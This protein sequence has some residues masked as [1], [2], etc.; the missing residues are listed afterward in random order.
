MS[1][2]KANAVFEVMN[3]AGPGAA[4][5]GK[6]QFEDW[7]SAKAMTGSYVEGDYEV[8]VIG[9][10]RDVRIEV[11][12]KTAT[13]WSDAL[14]A[15]MQ[16]AVESYLL[17][18]CLRTGNA[19]EVDWSTANFV[20]ADGK[21]QVIGWSGFRVTK[22]RDPIQ[23]LAGYSAE[24][25]M[26]RAHPELRAALEQYAGSTL[27]AVEQPGASMALAYLAVEGLVTFVLG[28]TTGSLT[29]KNDWATTAPLLASHP[30]SLLRLLWSTQ[31]GRHVD[32]VRA[33]QELTNQGWTPLPAT[34]CCDLALDIVVAYASTL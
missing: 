6:A 19:L 30:D 13:D 21:R 28:S 9:K 18:F 27:L 8:T 3:F 24:A 34:D 2:D 4:L 23:A 26:I 33:R 12:S 32:P 17:G 29:S 22:V 20:G 10:G 16:E 1:I 14:R 15:E 7:G 11:A 25:R 31:L 5:L